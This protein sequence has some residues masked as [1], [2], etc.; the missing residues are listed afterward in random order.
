MEV[1]LPRGGGD[2]DDTQFA[3]VT[4]HLQDKDG[5][6]IGTAN[7]N[8]NEYEVEFLDGHKD[9]LSAN[10]IAQHLFSQVDEE[11]HRHVLFDDI[12]DFCR[13]D[14]AI[15]KA[16]AFVTMHNGVKWRQFT[17]QRWQ[18]LC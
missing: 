8:M 18:L 5:R 16:D 17:T 14:M 11:G 15:D 13:N 7:N 9:S 10:L 2:P 3:C 1:A 4:K 6:P 12:I